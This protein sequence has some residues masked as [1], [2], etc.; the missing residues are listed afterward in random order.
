MSRLMKKVTFIVV[1]L[2][3]LAGMGVYSLISQGISH[4][5]ASNSTQSHIAAAS[6][7]DWPMYQDDL[8]RSG[9]NAAENTITPGNASKLKLH[10]TNTAGGSISSQVAAVNGTLYWGSWDGIEHA[11]NL[12]G[13]DI[14][15]ANLGQ[16]TDSAC[17]PPTVGIASTAA[18]ATVTIGGT[19]KSV[20]FVGG[21]NSV[22]YALDASSG[23]I[24]YPARNTAGLLPVEFTH[25]L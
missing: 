19:P 20:V 8:G 5:Y 15:T 3:F 1:V 18:V 22:F 17:N 4:S 23:A 14:W 11:T 16:T 6:A 10:W 2:A 13:K 24:L 7:G 25:R 21:G 9:F 12:S